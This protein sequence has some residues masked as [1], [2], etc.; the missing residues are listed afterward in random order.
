MK[1]FTVVALLALLIAVIAPLWATLSALFGLR[2]GAV[3]L[4]C[5]GLYVANGSKVGNALKITLGFLAGDLWGFLT[6]RALGAITL[7]INPN[8]LLFLVL[9]V[10]VIPAVFISCYLDKIFDLSAWLAGWAVTLIL[11]MFIP[12]D[13]SDAIVA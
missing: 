13:M 4:I 2:T 9:F 3:A 8:V 5:A 7:S 6:V 12:P 10:F 1:K 11:T